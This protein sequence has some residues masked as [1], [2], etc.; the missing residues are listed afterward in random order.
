M[1]TKN[2]LYAQ[3][4]GAT[5]VINVTA[6]AVIEEA[7]RH[8][9]SIDR[10][11]AASGG[12]TGILTEKI[13]DLTD[14]NDKDIRSI[15]N[16]PG[17]FFGTCRYKLDTPEKNPS[18]YDRIVSIFKE[19]NIGYFFYNGGNDSQDTTNRIAEWCRKSDLDIQCIGIPKTVDNDLAGTDS[20]PGFGSVAKYIAIS[21]TEV[22]A[23]LLSICGSSTKVFILETMGR[24]AGWIAASAGLGKQ[25]EFDSP[26]IILLPEY[27]FDKDAFLQRVK[28]CVE[29]IGYCFVVASEGVKDQN[30]NYLAASSLV[31]DSFGHQQLG[32]VSPILANMI[33]Q[34]FGYKYHWAVP[35]YLQRASK[36]IVS[37]TD[38][39]QAEAVGKQAVALAM[40]GEREVMVG[41]H[42][43]SEEPYKWEIRTTPLAQVA[44]SIKSMP[45]DYFDPQTS[46]LTAEGL[47]YYR[48]LIMGEKYPEY[49]NGLMKKATLIKKEVEPRLTPY[50]I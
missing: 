49:E 40:T 27:A 37:E 36:H 21:T 33:K 8:P 15:E 9:Q 44:N 43:V 32:G 45:D 5:A 2:I 13:F 3:S 12:I 4:G 18:Q 39:L 10:I 17:A 23:D 50:Q 11:Y 1:T 22:T 41:I 25:N 7:R 26:Q 16:E 28:T 35:D 19:Y 29:K 46:C 48:P 38:Y 34:E 47:I 42:R 6:R 24:D 14:S 31:I 30:N 20:C